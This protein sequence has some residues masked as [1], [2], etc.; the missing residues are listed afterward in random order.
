MINKEISHHK[1]LNLKLNNNREQIISLYINGKNCREIGEVF[2]LTLHQIY[3]FLRKN[4][5]KIRPRHNV[6]KYK[7]DDNYFE[8]IDTDEKAYWLGWLMGDGNLSEKTNTIRISLKESD[9]YVLERFKKAL[10][11]EGKIY[12]HKQSKNSFSPNKKACTIAF[13]NRKIYFDLRQLGMKPKQSLTA[14]FPRINEKFIFPFLRG[15]LEADGWISISYRKKNSVS[16]Q[17]GF[18]GTQEF[19]SGIISIFKKID[20]YFGIHRTKS[21]K[22]TKLNMFSAITDSKIEVE[23]ILDRLYENHNGVFLVRKYEKY[24]AI[25]KHLQEHPL[26]KRNI[27]KRTRSET[28]TFR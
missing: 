13:S 5:I 3:A 12:I 2:N 27:R 22:R 14:I 24:L 25:K 10:R 19:L 9:I 15:H 28:L 4:K 11:F 20:V 18:M 8:N 23:R 26:T 6:N 21:K 1:E 16:L 7:I 17:V